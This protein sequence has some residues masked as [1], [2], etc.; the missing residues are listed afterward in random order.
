MQVI[1]LPEYPCLKKAFF[2]QK[3]VPRWRRKEKIKKK[4]EEKINAFSILSNF[5][6]G[7]GHRLFGSESLK[8][9]RS[10]H[11]FRHQSRKPIIREESTTDLY[12]GHKSFER[13]IAWNSP[14]YSGQPRLLSFVRNKIQTMEQSFPLAVWLPDQLA[15]Y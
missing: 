10:R 8:I 12:S 3:N 4:K 15:R 7:F 14:W 11:S 5:S 1:H 13:A 6:P 2:F 9:S